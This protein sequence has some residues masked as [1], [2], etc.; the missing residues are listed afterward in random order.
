MRGPG[1][2]LPVR[3]VLPQRRETPGVRRGAQHPLASP[4]VDTLG[5]LALVP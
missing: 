3:P 5:R 1:A 2:A 4:N